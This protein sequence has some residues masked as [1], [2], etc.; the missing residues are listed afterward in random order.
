MSSSRPRAPGFAPFEPGE[1]VNLIKV[2]E[3]SDE[4]FVLGMSPLLT[5]VPA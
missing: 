5:I 4:L 3:C 2:E 1:R